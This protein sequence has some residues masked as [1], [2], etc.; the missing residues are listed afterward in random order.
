MMYRHK[1]LIFNTHPSSDA[2][3]FGA[4]LLADGG[5]IRPSPARLSYLG[6]SMAR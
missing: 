2:C 1:R 4:A 5:W 6:M 3:D